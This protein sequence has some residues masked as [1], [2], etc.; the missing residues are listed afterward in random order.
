MR[1]GLMDIGSNT[2]H[3]VI[4]E[5]DGAKWKK[6]LSEKEYAEIISYVE[7]QRLSADGI[8]RLAQAVESLQRLFTAL[9]CD[10]T[11][12]FATSALRALK[13]GDAVLEQVKQ[14]TGIEIAVI[15]GQ[16]EAYYDYVSLK[17]YLKQPKALGLDLGGGSGHVILLPGG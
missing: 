10:K 9:P 16:Q 3:A 17:H 14:Q 2:I 11:F 1:Y 13:N 5:L 15:S 8:E 6:V 12:Y 7:D 4:Y